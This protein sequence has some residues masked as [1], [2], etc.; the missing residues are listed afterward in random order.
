MDTRF[1]WD[2]LSISELYTPYGVHTDGT[3]VEY[4]P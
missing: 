3:S 1:R 4:T 2:A